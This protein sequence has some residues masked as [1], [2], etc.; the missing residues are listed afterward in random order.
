MTKI[1]IAVLVLAIA[2]VVE[3]IR[4]RRQRT[5]PSAKAEDMPARFREY[6]AEAISA[7]KQEQGVELR[8]DAQSVD[9]VEEYLLKR[10]EELDEKT[11]KG[12]VVMFGA[13]L[14][15]AII[16]VHGGEWQEHDK[17]GWG[18]NSHDLLSFPFTKVAKLIDNGPEDSISAF[19]SLIPIVAEHARKEEEK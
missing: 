6:A 19:L 4:M 8:F 11:Q 7:M 15:E 13:F 9:V 16:A 18:V 3:I 1:I 12:F 17:G 2:V 5:A 10:R 14:G